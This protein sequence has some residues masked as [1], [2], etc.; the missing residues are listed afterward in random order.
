MIRSLFQIPSPHL[1]NRGSRSRLP[2][3]RPRLRCWFATYLATS[4][5][6]RLCTAKIR[7]DSPRRR[8]H[9]ENSESVSFRVE[10]VSLPAGTG[11]GKFRE[12]AHTTMFQDVFGK[13]VEIIRLHRANEC[14]SAGHL[15][16]SC[17]GTLQHPALRTIRFNAP[18]L[19]RQSFCLLKIPAEDFPIEYR[20]DVIQILT[21]S[22]RKPRPI[23]RALRR[24]IV[25]KRRVSRSISGNSSSSVWLAGGRASRVRLITRFWIASWE[26]CVRRVGNARRFC[27]RSRSRS[28][29]R[30]SRSGTA[31][32]LAAVT[33]S[34]I[35]RLIPMPQPVTSHEPRRRCTACLGDTT[36]I[37][38]RPA[39]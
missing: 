1:A 31:R 11:H 25:L 34:W 16:W 39:Q 23:R 21:C 14:V 5:S 35:A 33:A 4:R 3:N 2:S 13:V 17:G 20:A 7:R 10:E 36:A 8:I 19:D 37:A 18:I 29:N 38:D 26:L 30:H 22:G 6:V 28:V 15:R 24:R 27:T 9:L 12:G 32:M